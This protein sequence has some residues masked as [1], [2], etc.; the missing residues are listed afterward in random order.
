MRLLSWCTMV[1]MV[2][3]DP[4]FLV[5]FA[6]LSL[7]GRLLVWATKLVVVTRLTL[8]DLQALLPDYWTFSM[9]NTIFFNMEGD[10]EHPR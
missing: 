9:M 3:H 2:S 1:L 5:A 8:P 4:D 6:E 10:T 7:K